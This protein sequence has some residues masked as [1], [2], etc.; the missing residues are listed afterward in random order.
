MKDTNVTMSTPR[1]LDLVADMG[2]YDLD[3]LEAAIYWRRIELMAAELNQRGFQTR[4]ET[5][6]PDGAGGRERI[7]FKYILV[8][9]PDGDSPERVNDNEIA[10][11]ADLAECRRLIDTV[12]NLPPAHAWDRWRFGLESFD[13]EY[14]EPQAKA[15]MRSERAEAKARFERGESDSEM[16]QLEWQQAS[17][18]LEYARNSKARNQEIAAVTAEI[19]EQDGAP[20]NDLQRRK[21]VRTIMERTGCAL[22]TAKRHIK[23]AVEG[24]ANSWGGSRGGGRPAKGE[25]SDG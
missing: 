15:D 22:D 14:T 18:Y 12:A 4:I 9:R 7:L 17:D 10:E 23:R 1:R 3:D 11:W 20:Q 16:F 19:I 21:M 25:V 2:R 8:Y 24:K 5:T 13:D 6:A